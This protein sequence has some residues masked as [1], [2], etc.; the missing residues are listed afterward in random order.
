MIGSIPWLQDLLM[1]FQKKNIE[2]EEVKEQS[3][4]DFFFNQDVDYNEGIRSP[5]MGKIAK[6][7]IK[8]N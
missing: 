4:E 8:E 6:K 5:G 2:K 3:N 1:N 7:K